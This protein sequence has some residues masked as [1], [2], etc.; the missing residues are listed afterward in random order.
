MVSGMAAA[1]HPD[2]EDPLTRARIGPMLTGFL[3]LKDAL[4]EL[5][6]MP[7][8]AVCCNFGCVTSKPC[9]TPG[10]KESVG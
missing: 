8:W 10:R 4:L 5:T 1:Y 2:S 3:R 6:R 9:K 7:G